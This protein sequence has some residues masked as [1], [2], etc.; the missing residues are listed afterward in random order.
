MNNLCIGP[1]KIL[2][3]SAIDLEE[4]AHKTSGFVTYVYPN[5]E[6]LA[7]RL[8]QITI[9][10]HGRYHQPSFDG[11]TFTSVDIKPPELLLWTDRC[12]W[13]IFIL[14][15]CTSLFAETR[16]QKLLDLGLLGPIRITAKGRLDIY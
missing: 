1:C 13:N 14:S 4:P 8:L 16:N 2:L 3:D 7:C 12:K 5:P 11:K 9:P 6:E 10:I 15:P